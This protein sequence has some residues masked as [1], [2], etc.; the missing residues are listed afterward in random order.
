MLIIF[1]L[2]DTIL[3]TS[4]FVTPFKM[5]QCLQRLVEEGAQIG[6]FEK[7]YAALMALNQTSDRSKEAVANFAA[8]IG[9]DPAK[10]FSELLAPLPKDFKIPTT[11]F[12][13]EIL[14]F[15]RRKYSL[16]LVTGGYPPF[17][18]EKMEKAG[19]DCSIFSKIAIPED[20]IKKPIYQELASIFSK[21]ADQVWVCGDRVEI[22]LAP[23][24][25]L[26]FHTIHMQWG[27]GKKKTA[28]WINFSISS[29]AELKGI[30][31]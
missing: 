13:K 5:R 10:A 16:A 18:M 24:Y 15:F 25:E 19:L 7:A 17:Q 8:R 4:G 28:D 22:D 6:D 21:S 31:K 1:D 30:I 14:T 11:P 27:R 20:S 23:A 26:G 12:A 3:D 2:D 29:L 9:C